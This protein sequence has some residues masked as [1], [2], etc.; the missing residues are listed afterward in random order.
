MQFSSLFWILALL[1]STMFGQLNYYLPVLMLVVFAGYA[2]NELHLSHAALAVVVLSLLPLLTGGNVINVFGKSLKVLMLA[3]L[4]TTRRFVV[5][6]KI[7]DKT[8]LIFLIMIPFTIADSDKGFSDIPRVSSFMFDANFAGLLWLTMFQIDKR[9]E[10]RFFYTLMLF[11]SQSL[12]AL[13]IHG[14]LMTIKKPFSSRAKN[15]ILILFLVAHAILLFWM[16]S[17][18][19]VFSLVSSSQNNLSLKTNSLAFRV[20]AIASVYGEHWTDITVWLGKGSGWVARNHGRVFH[21]FLYQLLFDHGILGTTGIVLLLKRFFKDFDSRI[22]ILILL[23][24]VVYETIWSF[25]FLIFLFIPTNNK[26][27]VA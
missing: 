26:V 10:R 16:L 27:R 20:I 5:S 11:A 14:I 21:N 3:L 19:D 8:S 22:L 12:G 18:R 9:R 2:K 23:T 15:K 13:L 17:L 24:N 6:R 1:Q 7:L 25:Y 4:F